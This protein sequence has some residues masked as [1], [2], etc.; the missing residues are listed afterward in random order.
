MVGEGIYVTSSDKKENRVVR[1]DDVCD[2]ERG[3]SRPSV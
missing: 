2:G 1:A 3:R